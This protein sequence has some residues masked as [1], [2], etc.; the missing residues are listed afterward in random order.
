MSLWGRDLLQQWETRISI[1]PTLEIGC[2]GGVSNK[3]MKGCH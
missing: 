2:M 1:P 3:E